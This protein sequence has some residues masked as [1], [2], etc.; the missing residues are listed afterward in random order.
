MF[1]I[2]G[3]GEVRERRVIARGSL[4]APHLVK[5]AYSTVRPA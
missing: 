5:D 1:V 3:C 4:L 2:I